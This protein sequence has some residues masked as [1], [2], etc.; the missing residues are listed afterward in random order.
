MRLTDKGASTDFHFIDIDVFSVKK[1]KKSGYCV[2]TPCPEWL[3]GEE[4]HEK[5]CAW[6]L[7][8]QLI[9][10]MRRKLSTAKKKIKRKDRKDC[11]RQGRSEPLAVFDYSS[12]TQKITFTLEPWAAK[13]LKLPAMKEFPCPPYTPLTVYT[14]IILTMNG[15]RETSIIEQKP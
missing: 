8:Y 15:H 14:E 6:D 7:W 3:K 12:A 4:N 13:L 11:L 1:T 5:L 9:T 2:L 10:I